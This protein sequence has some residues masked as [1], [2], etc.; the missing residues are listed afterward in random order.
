MG[1]KPG[2]GALV[3]DDI[4]RPLDY[5]DA[6]LLNLVRTGDGSAFGVLYQRHVEAARRLARELVVSPAEIDDV[7]AETF[8]RVLEVVRR[9]DGP[10]DAFRCYVLAAIRRVCEGRYSDP[11]AQVHEVSRPPLDPGEPLLD[12]A[13][14]G[15]DDALIVRAFIA[16]PE[17]WSALLWHLEIEQES[18]DEVAPLFGLSSDGVAALERRAREGVRQASIDAYIANLSRPW[19]LP[20]AERLAAYLRYQLSEPRASEVALHLSECDACRGVYA[21]LVDLG[22]TLRRVVAPVILGTVAASYLS[23]AGYVVAPAAVPAATTAPVPELQPAA[24]GDTAALVAAGGGDG[25]GGAGDGNTD[26]GGPDGSRPGLSG[27][28]SGLAGLSALRSS[29]RRHPWRA[30]AVAAALLGILGGIL[31]I[32]IPG[33]GAAPSSFTARPQAASGGS[34]STAASGLTAG[35]T[36]TAMPSPSARTARSSATPTQPVITSTA[37]AAP[38][39][40]PTPSPTASSTVTLAVSANVYGPGQGN[41]A[42]VLFQVTDTGSASTGTLTATITLPSGS[43]LATFGGHRHSQWTCQATSSGATCQHPAISAGQQVNGG[44][45]IQINNSAAC[46]QPVEVTVTSGSASASAQSGQD[47]QCGQGP[48]G[49]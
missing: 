39:P 42:Q 49:G 46:G 1:R 4:P 14:A 32:T 6:K 16:Q 5:D 34:A 27:G 23:S 7:V 21:E 13:A 47:I 35:P 17:R 25:E 26:P 15:L 10:T 28:L 44:I 11:H 33:Q 2:V 22:A 8:A 37:P 30:T 29:L 43:S 12:P 40:S 20:A 36:S 48:G 19:C 45:T 38:S 41:V 24:G 31:A 9:G 18:P 3:A